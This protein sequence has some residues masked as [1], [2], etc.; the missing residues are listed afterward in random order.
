MAS[1]PDHKETLGFNDFSC[2]KPSPCAILIAMDKNITKI[3]TELT[4]TQAQ[5]ATVL[6][7]LAEGATIPFIARYRKDI[8]RLRQIK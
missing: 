1:N 3:A 7:L 6:D 8:N 2:F 5:V 4:I